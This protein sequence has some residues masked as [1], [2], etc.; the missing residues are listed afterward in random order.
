LKPD[1]FPESVEPL[2]TKEQIKT[3][4]SPSVEA[5]TTVT[6]TVEPSLVAQNN[7]ANLTVKPV[8]VTKVTANTEL[9]I[10]VLD[11]L[12]KAKADLGEQITVSR[13]ADGLLYI[14]GIVETANR[15]NE[16]LQILQSVRN[17]PAVRIDLKTVGEAVAEQKN[18]PKP[19]GTVE[20]MDTESTET[21]TNSELLAYFKSEQA[22]RAFSGQ[23]I[24]R[25]SRAM[26]RAYALKRLVGQFKP[27]ELKQLSPEARAKWLGLVNAHARAFREDTESLRRELQ[28]VF[29][30]PNVNATG[31]FDVNDITAVPKAVTTLLDFATANDRIVISAFTISSGKTRFTA[32][33]TT[34]FWQSLKNAEAIA[35]KLQSVK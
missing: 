7:N 27:D 1:F 35:A 5:N 32:I 29:D 15:K 26:S 33:K 3:T 20:R 13:E 19:S 10:D 25:S 21:A 24:S 14:R 4:A 9:E 28:T 34:Q 23:M 31:S 18:T 22:A 11:L 8:V 30:A 6:P 12:N 2:L 17:N 16:I